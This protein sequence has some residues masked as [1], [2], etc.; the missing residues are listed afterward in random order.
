LND[1]LAGLG[2]HDYTTI[3]GS[4]WLTTVRYIPTSSLNIRTI[5]ERVPHPFKA[6]LYQSPSIHSRSRQIQQKEAERTLKLFAI[7]AIFAIPTFIIGVVGMMLLPQGN[8]FR[9]WCQGIGWWGGASHAVLLLWIIATIVQFG[10]ARYELPRHL[11]PPLNTSS[12][13]FFVRGWASLHFRRSW[14]TLIRFGNMNILVALSTGVAY[15]ASVVMMVIDIRTSP[16]EAAMSTQMRSYFDSCVFL[17]FFILAGKAL[18]ARAKLKVRK[19]LSNH[20][21]ETNIIKSRIFIIF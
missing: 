14:T 12:R 5:L 15:V 20:L 8:N 17:T 13:I 18:E 4:D 11:L 21:L 7:S 9:Q 10:I 2:L 19:A 6:S 3:S 16:R 1:Y